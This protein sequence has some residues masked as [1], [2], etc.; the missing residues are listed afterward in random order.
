M[1][2]SSSQCLA[3]ALTAAAAVLPTHLSASSHRE[4]PAI[5]ETPKVDGTDFYLFRSYEEGRAGFVTL[6]A[7]YLPLQDPYGGPN[8]FSMDPDAL[9]E[10][11]VDNNGNAAEDITFQFRFSNAYNDLR[12]P[13]LD[14]MIPV[15]LV[16]I[17][18]IGPGATDG[19]ATKNLIESFSVNIVRGDRRT[20]TSQPIT[21]ASNG[22]AVFR[23][24][25][26]NIGNKSIPD[27]PAYAG[28]HVYGIDIPGCSPGRMFVGQRK[29]PFVVNL[30]EVFD[31]V[32]LNPVGPPNARPNTLAD[33]N[34]TALVLEVPINCLTVGDDP[35]IG[36]WTT[37]SL[38]QGRV[39]NPRPRGVIAG[40]AD[41]RPASVEG[42]AFTQV[43]RLGM[44]L[45]N[46][47]VI[48]I[49]DKDRFNAS[50][51]VD[52]GQF[53]D[54][55]THPSLPVLLQVLF[56]VD[57]PGV[58]RSDLVA[59]FLTGVDG[60]NKP[61][62]VTASEMLRLNTSVSPKAA[63]DQ[64]SLGVVGGDTAGFPN[65]RRPGDDVVD[66]AL[67]AVMGVLLPADQAPSGQ[68]PYTDG[69]A[70]GAMDFPAAFPYLLQ[71]LPGSPASAAAA[72]R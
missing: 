32:N 36:A 27:Y 44:P 33:K 8:Y 53:A 45:V 42:G 26:D 62:A 30:G 48:G 10:I 52:D 11:H 54:Y 28:N 71:P 47:V 24:P 1:K 2:L 65:G 5:T 12:V 17:G 59:V 72:S 6:I 21:D 25:T 38:R 63:S 22:S 56:G 20:G 43:S 16:N 35:V 31:L 41:A 14:K 3:V 49:S 68:L 60:L 7:N 37:A 70:I 13:V 23:K 67:R 4:A 19:D 34:V 69:A 57:A 51:P 9:Y 29:D 61:A 64:V 15:P 50:E 18:P 66:I 40:A 55:V 58:V 46:E 39:L